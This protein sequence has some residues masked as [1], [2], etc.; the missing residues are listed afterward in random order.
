M[1]LSSGRLPELCS[2]GAAGKQLLWLKFYSKE[3]LKASAILEVTVGYKPP[4]SLTVL[5]GILGPFH[6]TVLGMN[7]T[8]SGNDVTDR[9]LNVL[10]LDKAI[11]GVA[12]SLWTTHLPRLLWS[13]K[14]FPLVACSHI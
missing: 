14:I 13:R 10:V 7:I 11:L 4:W 6:P 9:P 1:Y 3:S 2:A 5:T 12:K 8:R